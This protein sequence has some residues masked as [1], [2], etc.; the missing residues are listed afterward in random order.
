MA[1]RKTHTIDATNKILGRLASEISILLRGKHKPS[2]QP[3]KDLGDFIIVENVDKIRVTGKKM[4]KKKYYRH[5]EYMGGLKEIS[6]KELFAK[7]PARVL[8]LAVLR[9]MPRNKLARQQIKRL[10]FL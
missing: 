1:E 8:K 5:S 3:N 2:F 4:E 7:N 10:K 6:L 9:M